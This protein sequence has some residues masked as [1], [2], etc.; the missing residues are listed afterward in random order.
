MGS[1]VL[2]L[3]QSVNPCFLAC[4]P[5]GPSTPFGSGLLVVLDTVRVLCVIVGIVVVVTAPRVVLRIQHWGQALRFAALAGFCLVAIDTRIEH[6]GDW[7]SVRLLVDV[8]STVAAAAGLWSYLY[9]EQ[10][11]PDCTCRSDL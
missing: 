3:A 11:R 1:P 2:A 6:L 5:E 9:R 4:S 8:A 7:P 10:S